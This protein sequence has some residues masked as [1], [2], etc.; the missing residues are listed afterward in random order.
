[1]AYFEAKLEFTDPPTWLKVGLN[2][3]VDII[4]NEATDVLKVPKRFISR[5]NNKD[6]ILI[7]ENDT[8]IKQ[9]ISTGFVGNDGYV[10]IF[11]LEPGTVIVAP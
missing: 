1:M 3:D 6:Y 10:E 5:D 8:T 2:A 11:D 4:T 9:E 7:R